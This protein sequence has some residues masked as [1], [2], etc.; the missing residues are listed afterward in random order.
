[1]GKY[2][3]IGNNS[4]PPTL[5]NN[6]EWYKIRMSISLIGKDRF[7]E[8]IS[9]EILNE[10]RPELT[11]VATDKESV[12]EAV[13]EMIDNIFDCFNNEKVEAQK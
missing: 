5:P 10:I 7:K 9:E 1:M 8:K 4:Y 13:G 12:K 3:T 11:L 6:G 2:Y